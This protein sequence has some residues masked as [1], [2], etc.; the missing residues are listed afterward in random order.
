MSQRVP[1]GPSPDQGYSEDQLAFYTN[2]FIK[3]LQL[4]F[5]R[6]EPGNYRWSEDPNNTEIL[7]TDQ[8]PIAM[9][10]V[11]KK[12]HFV[13]MRGAAGNAGLALDLFSGGDSFSGRRDYTDLVAA[14][15]TVN[16]LSME[17][18]EAQRLAATARHFIQA[19]R[20]D[21]MR[22]GKVHWIGP[23]SVGPESP[24]GSIVTGGSTPGV[25]AVTL[26]VP[27][28]YQDFWSVEPVDNL[29]LKA[30][31]LRVT[32]E[33]VTPVQPMM[34][35]S[36]LQVEKVFSLNSKVRVARLTTPKPRK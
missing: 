8:S 30:I 17:G 35:G 28:Y 13:V 32:S 18:R 15:V 6:F 1:T 14:T 34:K 24:P 29:L 10:A 33:A 20:R 31:D 12:P 5:N 25:I 16:A 27:F 19:F 3:F 36:A 9:E 11:Q 2:V 22:G 26:T 21:I 4:I 23:L 7:I